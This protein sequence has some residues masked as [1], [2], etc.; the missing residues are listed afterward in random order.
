MPELLNSIAELCVRMECADDFALVREILSAAAEAFGASFFLFGMRT[1]KTISPPMQIAISN[2]PKGWRSR[3]DE[4]GGLAVDPVVAMAL[5]AKTPFRWDGLHKTE[6]QLE[7]RRESVRCGMDYGFSCPDRG[8]DGSIA[9]LSFCGRN[10]IAPEPDRWERTAALA[11]LL[12]SA[13]H[14]AVARMLE[15]RNGGGISA[16]QSLNTAERESLRMTAAGM[17][18]A[19]IGKVLGVATRTVRYYLDR[20]AE[21]LGA[22]SRK[23]A[24]TRAIAEGI[25]DL[26]EFPNVGFSTSEVHG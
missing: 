9:I 22:S 17:T 19:D 11:A 8:P 2:Y 13:T 18:A 6:Q 20:A 16:W 14:R 24:V 1:G 21:K 23:E 4:L 10:R 15:A 3:Y 12:A 25:I 5:Q 7:L 26:R